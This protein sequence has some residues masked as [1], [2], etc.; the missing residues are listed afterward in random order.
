MRSPLVVAVLLGC[1]LLVQGYYR[2]T[3]L[4]YLQLP[5]S[6]SKGAP[7][8]QG[9][10][11]DAAIAAVYDY[12]YNI[13]YVIG[14]ANH[15]LH[16]IDV[17][18][19]S[20]PNLLFTH[21]FEPTVGVPRSI[22]VCDNEVAVGFG[23]QTNVHEGHVRLYHTYVRG[24]GDTALH[25]DGYIT[26]GPSPDHMQF[27]ENC[28]TLVIPN[29]GTAGKDEAGRYVDPEGTVAIMQTARTGN[30]SIKHVD[31]QE[32]NHG[33]LRYNP[34][35]RQPSLYIPTSVHS[36][37][38]SFSQD[39]EPTYAAL[40]S[41]NKYAWVTL[42]TNNAIAKVDI[43]SGVV[44]EVDPLPLKDWT[45][46]EI[47]ASDRDGG[48]HRRVYPGLKTLRQPTVIK[49]LDIGRKT[50]LFVADTGAARTY[51]SAQHTFA[52]TDSI[53]AKSTV[54]SIDNA[55]LKAE[56][57][58]DEH[59]GRLQ[60]SSIDGKD[61]R[62]AYSEL[63][64]FGGRGFSVWDTSN[65]AAPVFDSDGTLE[66]YMEDNYKEVFNTDYVAN[67]AAYQS[68]EI[69]RDYVSDNMGAQVTAM[70]IKEDNDTT[71]L[72]VGTWST[73]TLYVYV[74]NST[75]GPPVPS[76]QSIYRAGVTDMPWNDLYSQKV[77]GDLHISD[78]SIIPSD[79]SPIDKPL[80]YVIGR[81]S[82]SVS[83][84]EIDYVTTNV[85]DDN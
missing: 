25:L 46:Y 27:T 21:E 6:L 9:L 12:H 10:N 16:V 67:T 8:Y 7:L 51:T 3:P 40:A 36:T 45:S 81:G 26:V 11:R 82:G 18:N 74:I 31:F 24:S 22:A 79:H 73:G 62:G 20:S 48:V 37:A 44:T 2:L 75:S 32:F 5:T 71:F 68:P 43:A 58:N 23:A 15:L 76:F 29:E 50:Y 64:G 80:V 28:L 78:L 84:Y 34:N 19:P 53:L 39:V 54:N 83:L 4:S 85:G 52:W 42:P 70:D 1:A 47:D 77:A 59:L 72:V 49:A 13:L 14:Q 17:A 35:I 63:V 38:T 56:A 61:F 66:Q 60:V 33:E 57:S 30:P 69:L 65:F 55:A 41:N